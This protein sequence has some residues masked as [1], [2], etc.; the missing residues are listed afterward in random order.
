MSEIIK[1]PFCSKKNNIPDN[2]IGLLAKCGACGRIM[3]DPDAELEGFFEDG[4]IDRE[5]YLK[6][7]AM[8]LAEIEYP[9]LLSD[10]EKMKAVISTSYNTACLRPGNAVRTVVRG[11]RAKGLHREKQLKLP[12]RAKF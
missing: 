4:K 7:L 12:N 9:S 2:K 11:L 6:T 1:C 3:N 8:H 5:E 10:P